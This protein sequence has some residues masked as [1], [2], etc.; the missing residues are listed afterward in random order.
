M[1]DLLRKARRVSKVFADSGYRG[2]KLRDRLKELTLP[3]LLEISDT[4]G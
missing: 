1:R 4:T 3:D 2:N